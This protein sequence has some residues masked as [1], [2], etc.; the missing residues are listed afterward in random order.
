[1]KDGPI[2]TTLKSAMEETEEID[3]DVVEELL[4]KTNTK[5]E[6]VGTP[7]R[8]R[9]PHCP[10]LDFISIRSCCGDWQVLS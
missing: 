4:K 3:H 10:L 8:A 7:L 9:C 2:Q 6:E 5:A 1:M